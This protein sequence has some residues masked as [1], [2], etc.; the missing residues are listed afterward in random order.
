MLHFRL[1]VNAEICELKVKASA[2]RAPDQ[3]NPEAFPLRRRPFGHNVLLHMATSDRSRHLAEI[4][5]KGE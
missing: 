1:D 3:R 2:I 4:S 5:W